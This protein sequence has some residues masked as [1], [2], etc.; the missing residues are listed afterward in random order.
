MRKLMMTLLLST[1]GSAAFADVVVIVNPANSA[2]ISATDIQNLF[3]G[4]AASF[5]NGTRAK[6]YNVTET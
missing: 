2:A 5:S 1:L 4:K 3:L 6:P